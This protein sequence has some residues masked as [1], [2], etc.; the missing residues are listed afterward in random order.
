[1]KTN[2]I[3][4]DFYF[5]DINICIFEYIYIKLLYYYFIIYICIYYIIKYIYI[6]FFQIKKRRL[7]KSRFIKFFVK[8][9]NILLIYLL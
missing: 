6:Y 1:M 3:M 8:K 7:I 2:I 5:R 4:S 9:G